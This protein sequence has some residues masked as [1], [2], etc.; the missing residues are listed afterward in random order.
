VS[1]VFI[2]GVGSPIGLS[3]IRELGKEGFTTIGIGE[4]QSIGHASKYCEK[5]IIRQ[6]TREGVISQLLSLSTEPK[7]NFLICISEGDINLINQ[8]RSQ[9]SACFTLLLPEQAQMEIVLDKSRTKLIADTVG[10]VSP[11]SI[12]LSALD[13]L[14]AHTNELSFPVILKWANPLTVQSLLSAAGIPLHKLQYVNSYEELM[15]LLSIY[16]EVNVF[17]L[18]QEYC[19]GK[20]LGQFFLCKDGQSYVEFQHERL[21]EWPPEGGTS[22]YC[23][24]LPIE[25]HQECMDKSKALLKELNWT[26]VAMVEYRYSSEKQQYVLMEINGRFWGSAPL[27]MY[28]GAGFA[29]NL[30]KLIGLNQKITQPE[31]S[32]QACL[33]MIPEL[34]R[35]YRIVFEADKIEDPNSYFSKTTAIFTLLKAIFSFRSRYFVFSFDDPSPFFQDMVNVF[36]KLL[37]RDES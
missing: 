37:K 3:L 9:L 22:T 12:Q 29:T 24:T 13:D 6:N 32:Q 23:R 34:K 21:H 30:V 16:K 5:A 27:A 25:Q 14:P 20:G 4:K 15:Q 1:N 36:R 2:L 19:E 18:I 7:S 26:G 10:I 28:A 35:L 11:I 17:P 33:Y 31:L 8:N